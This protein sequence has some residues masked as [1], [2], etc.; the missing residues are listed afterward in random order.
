MLLHLFPSAPSATAEE[1]RRHLT[2]LICGAFTNGQATSAA[3]AL[4]FDS[5]QSGRS[6]LRQL[7]LLCLEH[8]DKVYNSSRKEA[9]RV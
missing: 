4:G 2:R 9:A 7:R 3:K 6:T 5:S 1:Q 8:I